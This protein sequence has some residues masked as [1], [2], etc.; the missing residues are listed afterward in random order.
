MNLTEILPMVRSAVDNLTAQIVL[1]KML[2]GMALTKTAETAGS[3]VATT[4]DVLQ[5]VIDGQVSGSQADEDQLREIY[6][7]VL[8]ARNDLDTFITEQS[9]V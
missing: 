2:G 1:G 9:V 4:A 3:I 6:E 8:V 7:S 5:R